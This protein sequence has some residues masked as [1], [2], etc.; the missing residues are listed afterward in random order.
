MPA[1]GELPDL[2]GDLKLCSIVLAARNEEQRIERTIRRL[3][4]QA[5]VP[6]EIVIADDRS[7]DG[8]SRIL[9]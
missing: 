9:A 3:L 6:L 4:E 8:T 5:V 1:K 2:P 7:T